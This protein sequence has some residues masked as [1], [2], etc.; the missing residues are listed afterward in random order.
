MGGGALGRDAGARSERGA[1]PSRR[2]AARTLMVAGRRWP[3]AASEKEVARSNRFGDHHH[4]RVCTA[5]ATSRV[6]GLNAAHANQKW[7]PW[8][9]DARR[10]PRIGP[11]TAC[12]RR[13]HCD[14]VC[15]SRNRPSAPALNLRTTSVRAASISAICVSAHPLTA[16]SGPVTLRS[17]NLYPNPLITSRNNRSKP[18]SASWEEQKEVVALHLCAQERPRGTLRPGPGNRSGAQVPQSLPTHRRPCNDLRRCASL[19]S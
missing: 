12:P 4:P 3:R 6:A 19:P 7:F 10:R 8:G 17:W 15:R 5:V 2:A 9:T 16:Q 14:P 11:P 18:H 13:F 1:F